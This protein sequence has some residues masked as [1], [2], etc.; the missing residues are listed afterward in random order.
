[1]TI[2]EQEEQP[3]AAAVSVAAGRDG[4]G[5]VCFWTHLA[6]FGFVLTGWLYPFVPALVFYLLFLPAMFLQW[7]VNRSS[8][9]LNNLES[10]LRT[11]RWRNPQ[12]REEGAWLKTLLGDTLGI[13]LTRRQMDRVIYSVMLLLWLLALGHLLFWY[14]PGLTLTG[15]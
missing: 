6:V 2:G 12:N 7:R 1:M 14:A 9:M 11:G 8:C 15:A 3:Q 4:L 10:L 5:Q 13:Q